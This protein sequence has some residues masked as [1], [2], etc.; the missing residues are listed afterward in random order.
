M[1]RISPV[2]SFTLTA[3]SVALLEFVAVEFSGNGS[4]AVNALLQEA[5]EARGF[6]YNPTAP[7]DIHM[8]VEIIP[9]GSH[10]APVHHHGG[11][12]YAETPSSGEYILRLH[13]DSLSRVEAVVAVDG[14]NVTTGE[15][16]TKDQSGWL[17]NACS[18]LD[19][20]GWL[21]STS[22]VAAFTF[23]GA[24]SGGSYAEKTGRGT[25]SLG[26]VA[27]AVYAEKVAPAL[28]PNWWSQQM[29]LNIMNQKIGMTLRGS[30]NGA[31]KG[32]TRCSVSNDM[33]AQAS[34]SYS[35]DG[36][37]C[38]STYTT[39]SSLPSASLP[40][41]VSTGYGRKVDMSS[42]SVSF[43]RA[44]TEPMLT[45]LLRYATREKLISWGIPVDRRPPP[46]QNPFASGPAVPPPPGWRG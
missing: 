19:I 34:L 27:V 40:S 14:I 8:R 41:D 38:S 17:V 45:L 29:A 10:T 23:T 33:G 26:T 5:A 31:T 25:A 20:K 13:N 2:R 44:S 4:R 15:T 1:A 18:S 28:D 35:V 32:I 37:R 16:V 22:E 30:G 6:N 3:N 39:N 36:E 9:V 24:G 42:K 43:D 7:K 21:R 46:V 12:A 11:Q